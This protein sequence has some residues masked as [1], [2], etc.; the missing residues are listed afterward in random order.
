MSIAL[1]LLV[2][3][4][5]VLAITALTGYFVAQEFAFMAVD[6]SRMGGAAE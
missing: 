2:G 1:S 5:V 3:V 4:V 6:G